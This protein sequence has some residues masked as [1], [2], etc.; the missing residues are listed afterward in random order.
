MLETWLR[1]SR[2]D[3]PLQSCSKHGYERAGS[4]PLKKIFD[5]LR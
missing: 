1:E 4:S 2:L 5:K 3:S